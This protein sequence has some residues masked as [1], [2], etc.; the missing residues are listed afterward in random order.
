MQALTTIGCVISQAPY[1]FEQAMDFNPYR[2][3]VDYLK[4]ARAAP[5]RPFLGELRLTRD[6]DANWGIVMRGPKRM[7]Q[8][9]DMRRIAEAMA[10]NRRESRAMEG[11]RRCWRREWDSNPRDGCPPTRVPGVRLQP[12]G[13]LSCALD[14]NRHEPWGSEWAHRSVEIRCGAAHYTHN[15]L[16]GNTPSGPMGFLFHDPVR[17][18]MLDH[19][20]PGPRPHVPD[21][22]HVAVGP[23]TADVESLE[24]SFF[25]FS[26]PFFCWPPPSPW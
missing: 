16:G 14:L 12:L 8:E 20:R 19:A 3:D 2:V 7:L 18:N 11:N 10:W 6:H 13:H 24:W 22:P 9:E 5:I 17:A 15:H 4:A 21:R 1:R 26:Q 25:A 23:G